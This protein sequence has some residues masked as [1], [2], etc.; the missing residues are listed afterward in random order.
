MKISK[1]VSNFVKTI[2]GPSY[3][4]RMNSFLAQAQTREHFEQLEKIWFKNN[5]WF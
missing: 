2:K 1:I 5:R 4:E 3:E